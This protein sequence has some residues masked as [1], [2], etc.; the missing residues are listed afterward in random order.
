[1]YGARRGHCMLRR[2]K[3]GSGQRQPEQLSLGNVGPRAEGRADRQTSCGDRSAGSAVLLAAQQSPFASQLQVSSDML[4]V[5]TF[6]QAALQ[7]FGASMATFNVPGA[8]HTYVEYMGPRGSVL[9]GCMRLRGLR[10]RAMWATRPG[11]SHI[12]AQGRPCTSLLHASKPG[13][14]PENLPEALHIRPTAYL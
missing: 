2:S 10:H 8:A 11:L 4:L 7:I 6:E 3:S 5:S 14:S 9:R 13:T 1:V 12:V